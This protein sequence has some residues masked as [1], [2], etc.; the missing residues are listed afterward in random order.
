MVRRLLVT[1][2]QTADV[3]SSMSE[4]THIVFTLPEEKKKIL[5]KV[6]SVVTSTSRH[7]KV[8]SRQTETAEKPPSICVIR[9][10]TAAS[11][12]PPPATATP[13]FGSDCGPDSTFAL[14]ARRTH[15]WS[16]RARATPGHVNE[17]E[18]FNLTVSPSAFPSAC[19]ASVTFKQAIC[20]SVSN[21]GVRG[22]W[23]ISEGG[24]GGTNPLGYFNYIRQ[25]P[26]R[27]LRVLA[28]MACNAN[29]NILV[30]SGHNVV[31]TRCT[32]EHRIKR[33]HL[34]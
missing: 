9:G 29:E 13:R 26:V 22:W 8:T 2:A 25:S 18:P 17:E 1:Q 7:R 16:V 19:Q 28:S 21:T 5:L 12:S 33:M 10:G 34:E 15:P 27:W 23:G 20:R 6:A 32:L 30:S 24:R 3:T 31:V 14:S 4:K 11:I